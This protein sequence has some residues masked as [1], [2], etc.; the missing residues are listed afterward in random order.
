M[1]LKIFSPKKEVMS[2]LVE[3][4]QTKGLKP[5]SNE[6]DGYNRI[7]KQIRFL[8]EE[9]EKIRDTISIL[10]RDVARLDRHYYRHAD[11]KALECVT[12]PLNQYE[13]GQ[14]LG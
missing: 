7:A 9:N 2:N 5:T 1:G 11:E 8:R 12:T 13:A 3:S 6:N 14:N 4:R 10:K